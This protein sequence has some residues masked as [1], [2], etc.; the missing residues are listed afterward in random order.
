MFEFLPLHRMEWCYVCNV[1]NALSHCG[2]QGSAVC[3]ELKVLKCKD[4][5]IKMVEGM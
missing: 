1:L 2:E 3:E 5:N 4:I